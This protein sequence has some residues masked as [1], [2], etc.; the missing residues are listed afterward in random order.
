M[1][2][3]SVGPFVNVYGRELSKWAIS[4]VSGIYA[5][6]PVVSIS[7]GRTNGVQVTLAGL[8]L[9]LGLDGLLMYVPLSLL[10]VISGTDARVVLP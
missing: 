9:L 7:A 5:Q 10:P 1:G 4:S 2:S 6:Y 8:G 3:Q